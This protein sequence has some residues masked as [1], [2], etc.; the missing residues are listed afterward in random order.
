M[1]FGPGEEKDAATG[2]CGSTV[3]SVLSMVATGLLHQKQ[4]NDHHQTIDH[5]QLVRSSR[6]Q[7]QLIEQA[8]SQTKKRTSYGHHVTELTAHLVLLT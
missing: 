4:A 2:A 1:R 6:A 8:N 5:H 3:A 7:V